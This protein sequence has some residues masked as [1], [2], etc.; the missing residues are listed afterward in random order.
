MQRDDDDTYEGQGTK[1]HDAL[2]DA[3]NKAKV[4]NAQ[5]GR[6]KVKSIVI[7][8]ENPIHSY[9]VLIGPAD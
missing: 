4:K 6:Y 1:L 5:P 7:Q 2:E 8:T 9:I 3:W